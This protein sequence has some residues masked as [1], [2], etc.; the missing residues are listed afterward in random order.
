[1]S[2]KPG[3]QFVKVIT[4]KAYFLWSILKNSVVLFFNK[5]IFVGIHTIGRNLFKKILSLIDLLKRESIS[6]MAMAANM[7]M[8]ENGYINKDL[9]VEW[10]KHFDEY[11]PASINKASTVLLMDGHGSHVYNLPFL[12]VCT[13]NNIHKRSYNSLN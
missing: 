1:V 6:L 7:S 11:K 8:A 12:D 5:I 2:Y 4:S 9:M 13:A 10:V 3:C